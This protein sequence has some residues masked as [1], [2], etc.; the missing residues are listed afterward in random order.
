MKIRRNRYEEEM[1]IIFGHT[2][3]DSGAGRLRHT[4]VT[5]VTDQ[6]DIG[7]L[8]DY[9]AINRLGNTQDDTD[10]RLIANFSSSSTGKLYVNPKEVTS[11]TELSGKGLVT[12]AGTV[13]D[14][15]NAKT[16]E[17]AGIEGDQQ[18]LVN[19]DSAQAALGVMTTGEGV[20]CKKT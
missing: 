5:G 7:N 12:L 11:L 2:G 14:Y 20:A 10:L 8:A 6:V 17:Q 15:W 1:D 19:V 13:W 4:V 16:L 18:V 9:A 3:T